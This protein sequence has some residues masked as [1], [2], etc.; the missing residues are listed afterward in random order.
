MRFIVVAVGLL[1]ITSASGRAQTVYP[2]VEY[3]RG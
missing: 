2:D 3:V 1:G